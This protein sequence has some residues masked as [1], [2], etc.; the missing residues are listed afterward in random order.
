VVGLVIACRRAVWHE[1]V[2]DDAGNTTDLRVR[3]QEEIFLENGAE[4][5]L[6]VV[7][8]CARKGDVLYFHGRLLHRTGPT[9]GER[10]APLN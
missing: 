2:I 6:R 8:L 4:A 10:I 9:L 5:G 3:Q 7:S 1:D